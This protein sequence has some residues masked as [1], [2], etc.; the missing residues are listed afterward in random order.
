MKSLF[1][2][3]DVCVSSLRRGHAYLL[4]I[5]PMLTDDPRRESREAVKLLLRTR[6]SLHALRPGEPRVWKCLRN[7]DGTADKHVRSAQVRA[8]DDSA[9]CRNIGIPYKRAYALS[10]HALTFVALSVIISR[11]LS[12]SLYIYIYIYT[13]KHYT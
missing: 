8:C 7:A 1:A 3:L 5:V 10:S 11:S 6:T 12:L 13:Y 2:L 9:W 4:C